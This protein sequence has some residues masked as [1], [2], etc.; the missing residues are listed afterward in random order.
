MNVNGTTL[1]ALVTAPLIIGSLLGAAAPAYKRHNHIILEIDPTGTVVLA[2]QLNDT[3]VWQLQPTKAHPQATKA[4]VTFPGFSPCDGQSGA[5]IDT[6]LVK[7]EGHF[8]FVCDPFTNPCVDP[9]MDPRSQTGTILLARPASTPGATP[10]ATPAATTPA[11]ATP[12]PAAA[13]TTDPPPLARIRIT[14]E[15]QYPKLDPP[16]PISVLHNQKIPWNGDPQKPFTIITTPN[17]F[18]EG[19]TGTGIASYQGLA[20]CKATGASGTSAT[21]TVQGACPNSNKTFNISVK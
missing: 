15:N 13:V 16:D 11:A 3:V 18:C 4:F 19:D 6:C 12:A 10:A 1:V 8:D 7:K 20:V 17:N 5:R 2:P 21:Y 14:C 9:G